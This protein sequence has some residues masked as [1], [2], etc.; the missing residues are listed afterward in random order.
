[1][2]RVLSFTLTLCLI[3]APAWARTSGTDNPLP[4]DPGATLNTRRDGST[5][6]QDGTYALSRESQTNTDLLVPDFQ[7]NYVIIP[8]GERPAPN[9]ALV[10]AQELKLKMRELVS[11][12]LDTWPGD[13]LT[14]VVALPTTFVSLD[15]FQETSGLGRFMAE[16]LFY[17]FNTRGFG[18]RE[19]RTNG[20]IHMAPG[21]GEFTLSRALP[22]IKIDSDWAG[23]VVGT[24]YRDRDVVFVNVRMIR[25]S[26]GLV[27][28]TAQ[29]VLPMTSIIARMSAPPPTPPAPP[30]RAGSLRINPGRK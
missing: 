5:V 11:Q 29:L 28:R 30:L 26:D 25:P 9:P 14:N 8:G 7:G 16:S 6:L 1:M 17:E 13:S 3:T 22:D 24:Y 23:L 20:V 12:L 2:F 19:Y 18:V 4:I 15:N 21:R 10:D 27:L